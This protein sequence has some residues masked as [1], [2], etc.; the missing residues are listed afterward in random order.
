MASDFTLEELQSAT[1]NHGMPLEGLA[2]ATTP[3]GMHYVLTHFDIPRVDPGTWRLEVDGRVAR[4]LCLSLEDLRARPRVTQPVT[5]ECAGNGRARLEPRPHSQPWLDEAVGTG[6]W[7]GTPLGPLLQQAGLLDDAKEVLFSG[8]DRGEQGEIVQW[9]QRAL[10]AADSL[11][12]EVL[13]ADEMNGAPLPPQHGFPLRLIVP[14]WYGMAQV[15]WL[16]RITVLDEP[17]WGYQQNVFYRIAQDDDDPGVQLTRIYPRALMVPP[18][19]PVFETRERLLSPGPLTLHG[20]AWSGWGAIARVDVS[21]DAGEHWHQSE[22][23]PPSAPHA[24]QAWSWTWE[25]EE[26]RHELLCRATDAAGNVQPLWPRWNLKG[27]ANNAV[28]RLAVRVRHEP[29]A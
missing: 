3:P 25:A 18:G 12:P 1:R 29:E 6:E 16:H 27:V 8:L 9:Y 28:Q 2:Y 26:G 13:L 4:S 15:K 19:M 10:S 21:T 20:R 23:E 11:R 5:L 7:T 24:W 22:L 17:F 14:G